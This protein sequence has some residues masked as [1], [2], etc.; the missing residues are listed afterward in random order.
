M[1]QQ[2]QQHV[3]DVHPDDL[4]QNSNEYHQE[5]SV[6]IPYCSFFLCIM[7]LY[8]IVLEYFKGRRQ[9]GMKIPAWMISEAMKQTEHYQISTR[10]TPPTLVPTVDK[11]H[12]MI[13]QDTL[14]I[15]LAEHKGREEQEARENVKLVNEHLASVEIEKMV[16]GQENVIDDSLIS[17]NDEHNILDTRLEPRSDKESPEVEFTDVVIHVNV[18]EEDEE[19]TNEVYEL[20]RM[21]KGKV[22]EGFR[23]TPFPTSIR[24]LMIYTNLI[25]LDIEKLQ[26]LTITNTKSTSLSSSP[27]TKARFMPRKSF[28]TLA[29]HL[30]EEMVDSLPT[31]VENHVKEQVQ[32]QVPEQVRYQVPVYV[33]EGLILKRQKN[34][35]EMEKMIAKAIL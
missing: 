18:N 9:V 10:L 11:E 27:S 16:E 31:M 20:K 25:S 33:A 26:E 7:D 12:E 28:S 19:I 29:D 21:A 15:S 30:Q 2:Q 14:Q 8:G 17:R 3:A 35:E 22:V 24:S 4:K 34:K 13:L 6:A 32:K 5:S 1:A 23:N